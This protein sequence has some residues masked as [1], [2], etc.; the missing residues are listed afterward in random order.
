MTEVLR[1]TERGVK[2]T[3]DGMLRMVYAVLYTCIYNT[4]GFEITVSLAFANLDRRMD[5]PPGSAV[6]S[7]RGPT[8][9]KQRRDARA[10]FAPQRTR[11]PRIGSHSQLRCRTKR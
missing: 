1:L 9:R 6:R 5:R 4:G 2:N 3:R 7:S 10:P 11:H 8:V